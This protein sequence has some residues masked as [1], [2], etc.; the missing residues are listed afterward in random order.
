M[1]KETMTCP[2]IEK[3][4]KTEMTPKTV[5]L[6]GQPYHNHTPVLIDAVHGDG[7]CLIYIIPLAARPD[8]Y[9][10]RVDSSVRKMIENDGDEICELM[11]LELYDMI[12][13]EVGQYQ[14]YNDDD[15]DD[16]FNPWPALNLT[17]G[18]SWGL[19]DDLS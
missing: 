9:I 3:L 18:S 17:C 4:I 5:T 19:I 13:D 16:V 10:L 7:Q 8:Y 2:D 1:D 12:E 6:W 11:D 15:G 14:E